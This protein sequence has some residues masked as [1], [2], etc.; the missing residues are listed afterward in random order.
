MGFILCAKLVPFPKIYFCLTVTFSEKM[1]DKFPF[2][3]NL[4]P[5]Q[6]NSTKIAICVKPAVAV[7]KLAQSFVVVDSRLNGGFSA[8]GF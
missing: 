2:F 4:Y 8:D 3:I 1:L 5:V 7:V 6:V